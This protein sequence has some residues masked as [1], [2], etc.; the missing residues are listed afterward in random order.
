MSRLHGQ[1]APV[2]SQ[3]PVPDVICLHR[4]TREGG[5]LPAGR[6]CVACG[7]NVRKPK[8]SPREQARAKEKREESFWRRAAALRLELAQ[9]SKLNSE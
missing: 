8:G 1:D 7:A 6:W 9:Q 2:T 5:D 4:V 3:D